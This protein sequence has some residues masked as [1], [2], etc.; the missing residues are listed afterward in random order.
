MTDSTTE[1]M[2]V[3]QCQ[4]GPPAN[5]N[6]LA[7]VECRSAALRTSESDAGL[8][9]RLGERDSREASPACKVQNVHGSCHE[10]RQRVGMPGAINGQV[11]IRVKCRRWVLL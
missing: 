3:S 6:S 1:I 9:Q 7:R 11:S 2:K 5:I 8:R 10:G 4:L